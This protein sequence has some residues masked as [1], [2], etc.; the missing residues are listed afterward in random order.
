MSTDINKINTSH[1]SDIVKIDKAAYEDFISIKNSAITSFSE[2]FEIHSKIKDDV[3]WSGKSKDTYLE[4]KGFVDL[5]MNDFPDVFATIDIEVE[6]ITS[7]LDDLFSEV[8][9]A[10]KEFNNY[11]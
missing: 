3:E 1:T 6:E 10:I 11:D 8:S 4:A 9:N 5:F 7:I 2:I